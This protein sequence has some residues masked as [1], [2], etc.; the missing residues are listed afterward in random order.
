MR[1]KAVALQYKSINDL[2][3]IVASGA[4]EV[5]RQIMQIAEEFG[6]P[7]RRD[8]V[9]A[10]MLSRLNIGSVISP[11]SYRLVAEVVCFLYHADQKWREEHKEL[12]AVISNPPSAEKS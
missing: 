1:E 5:A 12:G 9:L 3:Q 10:D 8:D 2:P 11:E 4:G 6:V 7:V